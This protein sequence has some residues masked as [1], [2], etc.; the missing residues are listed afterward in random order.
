LAIR[1]GEA[2]FQFAPMAS[3]ADIRNQHGRRKV[4]SVVPS[5]G[6]QSGIFVGKQMFS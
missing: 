2:I 5:G 1:Y 3:E 6:R 4:A